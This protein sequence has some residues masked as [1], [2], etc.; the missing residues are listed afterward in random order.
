M[1]PIRVSLAACLVSLAAPRLAFVQAKPL[2][3]LADQIGL[4]Y[5][6]IAAADTASLAPMLADDLVWII[7]PSGAS[8]TKTRLLAAVSQR[9]TPPPRFEVDS[10]HLR[11]AGTAVVVDY[12]RGDTRQ[13]GGYHLTTWSRVVE[14]FAR[15]ANRWHLVAH[16]QTWLVS[17]AGRI[18]A[19]SVA[20]NAF[21]GRY[22]IGQD[23]IDNVH[24]EG[25]QLVATASGQS[26]GAV[27]VPVSSSAFSPDGVGA[28]MVF[29][30][31]SAGRVVG[32]VQRLASGQVIRAVRLH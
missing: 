19:D 17:P 7:G 30:R 23:Y 5:R 18:G 1:V 24:W 28:L 2:K 22:Q 10:V 6:A 13:L 11:P 15:G 32:Y 26:V 27:L 29:E 21:V 12:R 16:A 4:Q 8:L 20:L 25:G 3:E 31:D 9:Q 14:V